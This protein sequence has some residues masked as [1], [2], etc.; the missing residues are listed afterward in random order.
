[1]CDR[2]SIQSGTGSTEPG[3]WLRSVGINYLGNLLQ[4][5]TAKNGAS[6]FNLITATTNDRLVC[7]PLALPVTVIES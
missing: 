4:L 6:D 5:T 1:M 2:I 3:L 7:I